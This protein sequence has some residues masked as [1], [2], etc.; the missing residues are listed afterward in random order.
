MDAAHQALPQADPAG[1]PDEF[2]P[3]VHDVHKIPCPGGL[4]NSYCLDGASGSMCGGIV[5]CRSGPASGIG[6][7]SPGELRAA[8]G[9]QDLTAP[10]LLAGR[11][12]SA[13]RSPATRGRSSDLGRFRVPEALL[14]PSEHFRVLALR[15]DVAD[16][17]RFDVDE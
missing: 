8:T 13:R 9:V 3:F 10:G 15:A 2:L 7:G 14:F 16:S 6:S 1:K 11:R 12:L 17:C 5:S 4:L